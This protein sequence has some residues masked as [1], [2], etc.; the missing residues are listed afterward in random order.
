MK[1]AAV[2]T[3]SAALSSARRARIREL[4]GRVAADA[5]DV[6]TTEV[7]DALLRRLALVTPRA[8][9]PSAPGGPDRS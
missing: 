1:P 4:R 2:P 6:P 9:S 3:T 7:A 5:Y 8:G